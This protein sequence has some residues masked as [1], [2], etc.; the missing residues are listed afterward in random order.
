M[1]RHSPFYHNLI[2]AGK[3]SREKGKLLFLLPRELLY[4]I[5]T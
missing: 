3:N 5:F 2:I 1:I 4:D